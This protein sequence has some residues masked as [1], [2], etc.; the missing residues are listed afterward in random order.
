MATVTMNTEGVPLYALEVYLGN[1]LSEV[2]AQASGKQLKG[3]ITTNPTT[4]N[5]VYN[6]DY[7]PYISTYSHIKIFNYDGIYSNA[8]VFILTGST[9]TLG[10]EKTCI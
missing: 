1:S 2:C 6:S 9:G 5:I 8:K 10:A 7:S 3:F 4:S